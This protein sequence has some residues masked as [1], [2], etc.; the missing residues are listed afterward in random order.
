MIDGNWLAVKRT[1]PRAYA[2]Y[3]RH[4]S[5]AKGAR[6]RRRGSTQRHLSWADDGAPEPVL[7]GTVRLAQ[8]RPGHAPRDRPA[9]TAQCSAM[10]EL[11]CRVT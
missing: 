9:S 1:D 5:A 3:S 7:P 6:W 8:M 10:R 4:Y 2:L 11:G